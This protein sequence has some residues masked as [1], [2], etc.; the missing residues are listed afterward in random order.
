VEESISKRTGI[1][2]LTRFLQKRQKFQKQEAFWLI[3]NEMEKG[4]KV[5]NI[6]KKKERE[7]L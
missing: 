4:K 6:L 2:L 7:M 5:A 3:I 1:S